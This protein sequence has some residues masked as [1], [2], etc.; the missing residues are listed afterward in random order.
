MLVWE[1]DIIVAGATEEAENEY[2]SML[3][4]NFE[5]DDRGVLN[6]FLHGNAN[7]AITREDYC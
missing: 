7:H 6:W 3:N 5:M 1:D 2:K 4:E